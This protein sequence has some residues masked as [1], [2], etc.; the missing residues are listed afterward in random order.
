MKKII[1]GITG[2]SG[3]IYGKT[4][5][6]ELLKLGIEVRVIFTDTGEQVFEYELGYSVKTWMNHLEKQHKSIKKEDNHNLFSGI[7]SGSFRTDGMV[8]LPCSMG[9]LGE[10]ASGTSKNLLTRSA[11]VCLKERKK[12]VIVPREMPFNRIHLQNMLKLDEAN[13]IIMSASPAFYHRPNSMEDLIYFVVGK[14][15]DTLEIQHNLFNRWQD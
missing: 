3:S 5:V 1:V 4:M 10:I 2:A 7:A 9:T 13:A 8:V 6:E 11:D 15:M 14:I 12:L